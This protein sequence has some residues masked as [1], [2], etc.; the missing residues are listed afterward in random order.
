MAHGSSTDTAFAAAERA[1][2]NAGRGVVEIL[3]LVRDLMVQYASP[4]TMPTQM[5]DQE[6]FSAMM[7]ALRA[8]GCSNRRARRRPGK[9]EA[10]V[11]EAEAQIMAP[12]F[13]QK[14]ATSS[15]GRCVQL[16]LTGQNP[17][18]ISCC[19]DDISTLSYDCIP[20]QRLDRCMVAGYHTMISLLG[21]S[22]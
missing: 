16:R 9:V 21:L 4:A 18:G 7:R 6:E 19:D 13:K 14:T 5:L 17:V 12:L 3:Q 1:S 15:P 20:V 11:A 22:D 2:T 8:G 10:A